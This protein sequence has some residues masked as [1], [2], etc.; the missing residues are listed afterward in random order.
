MS[1]TVASGVHWSTA[2]GGLAMITVCFTTLI[3]ELVLAIYPST[4]KCCVFLLWRSLYV[5][6]LLAIASLFYISCTVSFSP[7]Y[8]YIIHSS[9]F[10][11]L[12][13]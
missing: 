8:V 12:S 13:V 7:V 1:I 3:P 5:L 6:I 4:V 9:T 10:C 11:L 2:T